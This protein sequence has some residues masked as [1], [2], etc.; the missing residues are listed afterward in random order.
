MGRSRL[1]E[2]RLP[3][4]A[5]DS[6][7]YELLLV[8]SMPLRLRGRNRHADERSRR[9]LARIG[10]LHQVTI[11]LGAVSHR[12]HGQPAV[13]FEAR[14]ESTGVVLPD[15]YLTRTSAALAGGTNTVNEFPDAD[16][17]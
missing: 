4:S 16:S 11:A 1:G 15:S 7:K 3:L 17:A 6:S 9:A 10:L 2:R 8:Q 5:L 12:G 14:G 13:R